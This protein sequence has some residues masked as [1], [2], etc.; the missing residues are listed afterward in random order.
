MKE[1][2]WVIAPRIKEDL[3]DQLLYNRQ[4]TT[5]LEKENFLSSI[6]DFQ[7]LVSPDQLEKAVKRVRQAIEKTEPILIYGDFDVDGVTST[8]LLWETLVRFGAKVTPYIPHREKEGYG[9]SENAILEAAAGGTKLI[10]SVDCGISAVEEVALAAS[11][12]I[13]V[14]ITDHHHQQEKVPQ[15]YATV[16]TTQLAGVGVSYELSKA[17]YEEFSQSFPESSLDLVALG[18]LADMVTLLGKNR[19]LAKQGLVQ[20]N[21]TQREGLR[22]LIETAGIKLG[23]VGTYEVGFV[24]SP[25]LN[26]MGRLEHAMDSLRLLLTRKKEK[27]DELAR[28]LSETN[29]QRQKLTLETLS[30]AREIFEKNS[31]SKKILVLS[32]QSWSQG[33]IG[34]VA[35]RLVEELN[36]PVIVVSEGKEF[37]KGSA[38]SV[39]GFNIVEA[40]CGCEDLLVSHGGHP[41]AAGFTIETKNLA[42]FERRLSKW[43]EEKL[44][45]TDLQPLVKIEA[46]VTPEKLNFETYRQ[47]KQFE[48]FGVGNPEPILVGRGFEVKD[49][50]TVGGE[51]KHLK[52]KLASEVKGAW[53]RQGI[54]EA[55]G[56]GLGEWSFQLRPGMKVDLAFVLDEDNWN[57]NKKLQLKVK[58]LKLSN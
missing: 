2:R 8:A 19:S 15:A 16:H 21:N 9:L 50:R 40:I 36:R 5:D 35:G 45:E 11:L 23:K 49:F 27:A 18:T 38:R 22:S 42:D 54:F 6:F 44:S 28:K 12:G 34:L 13:D 14:I 58:D 17:I 32:H 56:F 10:I 4:I 52:L 39:N 1:K 33:I 24:L 3:V 25:R 7:N 53:T 55:I 31:Q 46:E 43:V 48:P 51:G 41:Q 26:A 37:S 29:E 47:I 20:L 57:G 30:H